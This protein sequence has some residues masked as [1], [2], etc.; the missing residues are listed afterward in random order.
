MTLE[1]PD[2]KHTKETMDLGKAKKTDAGQKET[3]KKYKQRWAQTI[4]LTRKRWILIY[5]VN[6]TVFFFNFT[7]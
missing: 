3:M 5:F 6:V 4:G 2:G 1:T 7:V